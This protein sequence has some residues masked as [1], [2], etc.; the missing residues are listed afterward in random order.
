MGIF[1]KPLHF[2]L[3]K[4]VLRLWEW[5]KG[6]GWGSCFVEAYKKWVSFLWKCTKPDGAA[7]QGRAAPAGHKNRGSR[8]A[9]PSRCIGF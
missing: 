7:R 4:M 1:T 3:E 8:L 9:A 5:R 2:F 6:R